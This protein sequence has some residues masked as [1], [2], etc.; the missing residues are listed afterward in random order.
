MRVG[1]EWQFFSPAEMYTTFGMLGW[2]EEGQ[3]ALITD[4]KEPIWTPRQSRRR[5]VLGEADGK[6]RLLEDGTLE[7]DVRI[8]YT[9]HLAFDKKEYNDDDSP[10]EREETL[11]DG[12]R[13]A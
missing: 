1:E 6:F 4:A 12:L 8:E 3:D 11:R 13:R 7:G 5:K 2:P 9:G 10:A